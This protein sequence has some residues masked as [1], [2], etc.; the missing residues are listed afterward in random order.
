[1]NCVPRTEIRHEAGHGNS[2]KGALPWVGECTGRDLSRGEAVRRN[3]SRDNLLK[4]HTKATI[5]GVH[6]LYLLCL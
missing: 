1:M 4:E 3:R 5:A 2:F 6:T